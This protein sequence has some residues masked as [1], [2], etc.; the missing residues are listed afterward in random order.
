MKKIIVLLFISFCS[1]MLSAQNII[2]PNNEIQLDLRDSVSYYENRI[3]YYEKLISNFIGRPDP[4][5]LSLLESHRAKKTR[6]LQNFPVHVL[7]NFDLPSIRLNT[8]IQS[9]SLKLN[10]DNNIYKVHEDEFASVCP[11]VE[12]W[13]PTTVTYSSRPVSDNKKGFKGLF[14]NNSTYN[15]D[16]TSLVRSIHQQPNNNN[17]LDFYILTDV[18]NVN[19]ADVL[20]NNIASFS[21]EIQSL[22]S[23]RAVNDL[24]INHTISRKY[25]ENGELYHESLQYFD[26]LGLPIQSQRKDFESSKVLISNN[27]YDSFGRLIITTPE[28]P[29]VPTGFTGYKD[30]FTKVELNQGSGLAPLSSST[31]NTP[32]NTDH[33]G[34]LGHYYSNNNTVD[35]YTPNSSY[36]YSVTNYSNDLE[37]RIE[38]VRRAGNAFVENNKVSRK[39]YSVSTEDLDH[40]LGPSN[41]EFQ[42]II[43]IDED[44]SY[45]IDYLNAEG[46]VIAN[47]VK[48]GLGNSVSKN[49]I[50]IKKGQ[51][52]VIAIEKQHLNS[53]SIFNAGSYY[54]YSDGSISFGS[55]KKFSCK[56]EEVQNAYHTRTL[57]DGYNTLSVNGNG[58]T[59]YC[60]VNL[61]P[62]NSRINNFTFNPDFYSQP[63]NQMVFLKITITDV[64]NLANTPFYISY[65]TPDFAWTI[66][67][68]DFKG[69]LTRIIPPIAIEETIV[70]F[71]TSRTKYFD[72]GFN[73][74]S[75]GETNILEI[76]SSDPYFVD[77]A[78]YAQ[79]I[80][81]NVE[82][83]AFIA[84][85][86]G[87]PLEDLDDLVTTAIVSKWPS[88]VTLTDGVP[89]NTANGQAMD[90]NFCGF[91]DS[92]GKSFTPTEL[93]GTL[94]IPFEQRHV[95]GPDE[96][97]F[98]YLY[99]IAG[100]FQVESELA[101][102]SIGADGP[103]VP[104]RPQILGQ[105]TSHVLLIRRNDC[106]YHFYNINAEDASLN[107]QINIPKGN[108]LHKVFA[109]ITSVKYKPSGADN[110]EEILDINEFE[111]ISSINQAYK[112]EKK[113][114]SQLGLE[115]KMGD[116]VAKVERVFDNDELVLN[117]HMTHNFV[118]NNKN[119]LESKTTPDE[120]TIK[121]LYNQ[122][123]QLRFQQDAQ[124]DSD[125]VFSYIHYDALGR[126]VETGV[127]N[128]SSAGVFENQTTRVEEI[129][130]TMSIP[131]DS[132]SFVIKT[133]YDR[134]EIDPSASDGINITG[135]QSF[136]KQRNLEGQVSKTINDQS[137]TWYSYNEEGLLEW[138]VQ[139]I[140]G[141]VRPKTINYTYDMLGNI[142]ETI[143]Q[144]YQVNYKDRFEHK[145]SYNNN[146]QLKSVETKKYEGFYN[147]F[148]PPGQISYFTGTTEVQ[149]Q[150]EFKYNLQGAVQR[151]ELGHKLQGIDYTYT[152]NGWLKS[153]NHPELNG[154]T[155]PTEGY[156]TVFDP[157]QDG[158]SSSDFYAD[159]FGMSL[160]YYSNDYVKRVAQENSDAELGTYITSVTNGGDY[161][162]GT[163][164]GQRWNN[165]ALDNS[166]E[167]IQ[168]QYLYGYDRQKQ[169]KWAD[170]NVIETPTDGITA[171]TD[172]NTVLPE[173]LDFSP[174]N[175][176]MV[177][178][179][180]SEYSTFMTDN[181]PST[182]QEIDQAIIHGE[183]IINTISSKTNISTYG[184][185][186]EV[187]NMF[188]DVNQQLSIINQLFV[189]NGIE[190]SYASRVQGTGTADDGWEAFCQDCFIIP[191]YPEDN[192]NGDG[193][194]DGDDPDPLTGEYVDYV[195]VEDPT[196]Y[197][198]LSAEL[199][200][201]PYSLY[202]I[203]YD[204][205]GN[206]KHLKR[207]GSPQTSIAMDD[208]SY[209]YQEITVEGESVQKNNKLSYATD[210]ITSAYATDFS[211]GQVAGNY[212]YNAIGQMTRNAADG[213]YY[214]YAPNGLVKKIST[215]SDMSLP[216]IEYFYD[217]RG[218][219]LREVNRDSGLETWYIRDVNGQLMCRYARSVGSTV[220]T[221]PNI[222]ELPI[223]GNSRL[224][225][226]EPGVGYVYEIKDHLG[227]VRATV[228]ENA[229]QD[230]VDILSATD[231]YPGGSPMP[232]RSLNLN[233][234]RYSYQGQPKED[235]T[236]QISF[237]LREYDPQLLRFQNPDPYGQFISPY[238]AMGNNPVNNIDPDGGWTNDVQEAQKMMGAI[239]GQ[240]YGAL[241]EQYAS[242]WVPLIGEDGKTSYIAEAGDSKS[243]FQKQYGLTD[244]E[245]NQ[246]VGDKAIE[247]GTV[248][249]GQD[250]Y[251]TIGTEVLKFNLVSDQATEQRIFDHYL[252]ARDHAASK[253]AWAFAASTYFFNRL[254]GATNR[255]TG[256]GTVDGSASV[257]TKQGKFSVEYRL[258][259]YQV[260]GSG[261]NDIALGVYAFK[262]D[263][264]HGHPQQFNGWQEN[265]YLDVFHIKSGNDIGN[266]SIN[267]HGNNSSAL[268]KRLEKSFPRYSYF[269][270]NIKLK[271][272]D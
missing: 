129:A 40:I 113:F 235:L 210:A 2:I 200:P 62:S 153:I 118:Y 237:E 56:I 121:Y 222:K 247:T 57:F 266:Y 187:A 114:E 206:I 175:N 18:S 182:N 61:D 3:T 212:Q 103:P 7:I 195:F 98:N 106:K 259:L 261:S 152:V 254:A 233:S 252:F 271:R 50:S 250:V 263:P 255:L 189:Q 13:N 48:S 232:G 231:Y 52:K 155:S 192:G 55:K 64:S 186:K 30:N 177:A 269:K 26:C 32:L 197:E 199:A 93:L 34:T 137:I 131:E 128:E 147:P 262:I 73:G 33:E 60:E 230:G 136:Y 6:L 218:H 45:I 170:Y 213:F 202:G 267:T 91:D 162:S 223:Y 238:L 88:F 82:I 132:K 256:V 219:K 251:N 39:I 14:R 53:L 242:P 102:N 169:I 66:N 42:K 145:Y 220:T 243:T 122:W 36:P 37:H 236:G 70:P 75:F 22:V 20:N 227:N 74:R 116:L 65:D 59:D 107:Y 10:F 35:K 105:Q 4:K 257:W 108:L 27:I 221:T 173:V 151:V 249:S 72:N 100:E 264:K 120:G 141:L 217:D 16:I 123:N 96:D 15:L 31:I 87:Y 201:K 83:S 140:F 95:V 194:G 244:E 143:Y 146:K 44:G 142:T 196:W 245:T 115:F 248:I 19:F 157:G 12:T 58:S 90:H 159:V 112:D 172:N 158:T 207:N 84:L 69:N 110:F 9:A 135:L 63:E 216:K 49:H 181:F 111:N 168:N 183:H 208:I 101:Y 174:E 209:N 179:L 67:E 260:S 191:D 29:S 138:T 240:T 130:P 11:I 176:S 81:Y 117:H 89:D 190:I 228:R 133:L 185:Y 180:T 51:T 86:D 156:G 28:A 68:Y 17:G 272:N 229:T 161:F 126:V 214:D 253:G 25:D 211:N 134:P 8:I 268:Y 164:R 203:Q 204:K 226:Y 24:T 46:Q 97:S 148:P 38:S 80:K 241:I 265:V 77:A 246:I 165:L 125:G 163:I 139:Y 76:N 119:Q 5:L 215:S 94:D 178:Q 1:Y 104:S 124:Q 99:Q 43:S 54:L 78:Q 193:D 184:E 270:S 188:K 47:A 92:E 234:Y 71:I 23:N 127:A 85:L 198:T 144:K 150:A 205:Q 21:I 239:R 160:D 167:Y 224:G 166:N 171:Y 225:I 109:N 149:K 41:Q 258:P 79:N 154:L